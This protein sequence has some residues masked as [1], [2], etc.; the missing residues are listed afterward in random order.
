M[1]GKKSYRPLRVGELIKNEIVQMLYHGLKDP[2][3]H[4]AM[5]TISEVRVT[6]DLQ[7]ATVFVSVLEERH[8]ESV[9]EAFASASGFIRRELGKRLQLRLVPEV[10]FT[11]DT[12]LEEGLRLY[13]L[14][15]EL[16][17]KDDT[18]DAESSD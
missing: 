10:Q 17:R 7:H 16:N 2:R 15:E 11:L 13:S 3:L 5:V 8:R 9:M 6:N 12:S 14:I 4:E 18:S 1:S